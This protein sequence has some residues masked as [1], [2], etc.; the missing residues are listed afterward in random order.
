MELDF[1]DSKKEQSVLAKQLTELKDKF[2]KQSPFLNSTD[3]S[4]SN[5]NMLNF[6]IS[7]E[8]STNS[9]KNDFIYDVIGKSEQ[10]PKELFPA[11]ADAEELAADPGLDKYLKN[12]DIYKSGGLKTNNQNSNSYQ[13]THSRG[14]GNTSPQIPGGG[15]ALIFV[16][17]SF[18]VLMLITIA[19]LLSYYIQRFRQLRMTTRVH[20]RRAQLAKRAI[21]QIPTRILEALDSE[22]DGVD[23]KTPLEQ[24]FDYSDTSCAICIENHVCGDNVRIL[25]CRHIF[26]KK[27]IDPWLHERQTCP[28]CK[29]DILKATGHKFCVDGSPVTEPRQTFRDRIFD[30]RRAAGDY[31]LDMR[32]ATD[33]SSDLDGNLES[34]C[35]V[36]VQNS[37]RSRVSST[38]GS[39]RN[40][41]KNSDSRR[42]SG[43]PNTGGCSI[44]LINSRDSCNFGQ[45][46]ET[47][48]SIAV[49]EIDS[50]VSGSLGSAAEND[51]PQSSEVSSSDDVLP[52]PPYSEEAVKFLQDKSV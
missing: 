25:P 28:I 47:Q 51:L 16:I 6:Y 44:Q 38:E 4:Q 43:G 2:S 49:D 50:V 33:I 19:W 12:Q 30:S 13:K 18:I 37:D 39:R 48:F 20:R 9:S 24:G 35:R 11:S 5:E 21:A 34:A 46:R 17:V 36:E 40:S 52:P 41:R 23:G 29:Y 10:M 31:V 1:E 22:G 15:G 26:H 8:K 42:N 45:N 7:S 14:D 27:C 32:Q 3:T